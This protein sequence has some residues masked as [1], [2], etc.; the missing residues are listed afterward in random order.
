MRNCRSKTRH[1]MLV[2]L[3]ALTLL[4]I[5]CSIGREADRVRDMVMCWVECEF[6][7]AC[8]EMCRTIHDWERENQYGY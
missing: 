4:S 8:V 6:N 3:L 5:S 7:D 1:W 2:L